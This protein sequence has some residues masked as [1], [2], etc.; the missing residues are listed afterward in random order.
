MLCWKCLLLDVELKGKD[1]SSSLFYFRDT[2][3]LLFYFTLFH[4]LK[5]ILFYSILV[6]LEIHVSKSP[7]RRYFKLCNETRSPPPRIQIRIATHLK[8]SFES[9]KTQWEPTRKGEG[10]TV[11]THLWLRLMTLQ[12]KRCPLHLLSFYYKKPGKILSHLSL[13]SGLAGGFRSE[14]E[15]LGSWG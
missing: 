7:A 8:T 1:L 2:S 6:D 12:S 4:F 5:K 13:S 10:A 11:P 14:P 9:N 3:I 15:Q